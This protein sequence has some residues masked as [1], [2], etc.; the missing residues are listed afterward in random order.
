M[1]Y[2]DLL[3]EAESLGLV[4]KE[5]PLKAY[6]GRIKANRIAIKKDIPDTEKKCTLVEEIGH[7]VTTVGNILNQS[8]ISNRK[9]E[10]IARAW[11]Y[12]KTV[13]LLSLINGKKEGIKNRY[14]LAEYLGVTEDFLEEVL[15]YYKEKYGNKCVVGDF[16][17]QF[18]PLEVYKR[19]DFNP[20][21]EGQD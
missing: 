1:T 13:S 15:K 11:G 5:K 16:V 2:E 14:E 18:E 9:Q 10:R 20:H 6:N 19:I 7:H 8:D 4:V 21:C 12:R 17:I 3:L